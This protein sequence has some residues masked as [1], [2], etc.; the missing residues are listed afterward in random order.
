VASPSATAFRNLDTS[1]FT[2]PGYTLPSAAAVQR[3]YGAVPFEGEKNDSKAPVRDRVVDHLLLSGLGSEGARRAR[4]DFC[5]VF[6]H[7][8]FPIIIFIATSAVLTF[9]IHYSSWAV[10]WF[11]AV[12]FI[13]LALAPLERLLQS[14]GDRLHGKWISFVYF[15]VVLA[16]FLAVIIASINYESNMKPYYDMAG[17]NYATSVD[18]SA[19]GQSHIDVGRMMF[20]PGARLDI[21]RSMGVRIGKTY[22]VAP[23]VNPLV[24]AS[25]RE[26]DFWAVGEDCCSS[27]QPQ[28]DWTCPNAASQLANGGLRLM[29]DVSRPFYRMAVQEAEATYT[30]QAKHPIFLKWIQDPAAEMASWYDN[31]MKTFYCSVFSVVVFMCFLSVVMGLFMARASMESRPCAGIG[32]RKFV[33]EN[34]EHHDFLIEQG[35]DEADVKRLIL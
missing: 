13:V 32:F 29:S 12:V 27:V 9:H 3:S 10:A 34:P 28:A 24:N 26:Y 14:L 2:M 19:S 35:Y 16:W 15:T 5:Q 20:L 1:I 17:L 30:L 25:Q 18:P 11:F 21:D 6:L 33:T 22:C 4:I 31:G 8:I 23:I 7:A